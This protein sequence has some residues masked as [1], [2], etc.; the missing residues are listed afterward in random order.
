MIRHPGR[1]G[2]SRR[3]GAALALSLAA[4]GLVL[5]L[6]SV[7]LAAGPGA[8]EAPAP[9]AGEH[10]KLPTWTDEVLDLAERLPVQEGGRV[11]PL[12][13][14]ARF[15][16]LRLNGR[17]THLVDEGTEDEAKR[18][19][20][21]WALD[22][23]FFPERARQQRVFLIQEDQVLASLDLAFSDRRKRDR[24]SYDDLAPARSRLATRAAQVDALVRQLKDQRGKVRHADLT[25]AQWELQRL[26]GNVQLFEALI[27]TL[28]FARARID[29]S[30][31]A[32]HLTDLGDLKQAAPVQ[33]LRRLPELWNRVRDEA[34]P[35]G[36]DGTPTFTPAGDALLA[37]LA[38]VRVALERAAGADD[39][40]A[41]FPPGPHARAAEVWF[42]PHEAFLR[43]EE[44]GRHDPALIEAERS[45]P[46]IVAHRRSDFLQAVGWLEALGG[47][48]EVRD[49]PQ[50]V[51]S[52]LRPMQQ[53]VVAAAERRGEYD[54]VGL[55]VT[56]YRLDPLY[57]GLVLYV[58]AFVLLA[59][60]WMFPRARWLY[61]S[62][63]VL[64]GMGL[65]LHLFGITLRC[66]IRGRPPVSTLYE[67]ILFIGGCAVIACL[68]MERFNRQRIA[69]VLAA[70][71]GAASLWLAQGYEVF[72]AEDTM[73]ELMA[74]LDT[75]FWLSTHVTTV[76]LGY[77]A[78]LLAAAIGHL[79]I[80]GRIFRLRAGD[81]GFYRTLT[82]M[83]YGVLA[84]GLLFSVVGTILGGIWANDSWG[85]FWGW[86]PK[87]NGALMICL[88]ELA[89][90]H[91]RMGGY[92]KAHGLAMAAVA[93]GPIVAF[94][95][96]G[97]NL[98]EIGLH[99]YGFTS[100]VS[101]KLRMFYVLEL[102]VLLAG[103]AW[104]LLSRRPPTV[105]ASAD[106]PEGPDVSGSKAPE[107]A[108]PDATA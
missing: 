7:P 89:I 31:L 87:E 67:T 23:L 46:E 92:I 41:L 65:A 61:V 68:V 83:T 99:S 105:P 96:W 85:R 29:A 80:L 63:L 19:A 81:E 15:A 25:P 5:L 90:L 72:K 56:Y 39:V 107:G 48:V 93:T 22:A 102:A 43:A 69:I 3:L 55:E 76:T 45:D 101:A 47:A 108:V 103:F 94:S 38:E 64:L 32:A 30:P 59:M 74:V 62:A 73:P 91:A 1:P 58:F 106:A 8:P 50:A 28:D 82:R 88:W 78:G 13:T 51:A 98:L 54:T 53:E 60:T 86:D 14:W 18:A 104:W 66:L 4:V 40:L 42:G 20:L 70:V 24:Y 9:V 12:S 27:G 100:G 17:S 16:L 26:E 2:A 71:L 95:W 44:G 52:R 6:P 33:V 77:A 21:A 97:V 34:R 79:Y 57:Y 84:F 10:A 35:P 49:D 75:N 37:G 11:K 36:P